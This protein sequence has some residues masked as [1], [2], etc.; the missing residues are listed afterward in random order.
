MAKNRKPAKPVE[1]SLLSYLRE[2][3]PVGFIV[4]GWTFMTI[5]FWPAV[6]LL[7]LGFFWLAYDIRQ[8]AFFIRLPVY[9]RAIL[10]A[11][12]VAA[13]MVVLW[14][15][16]FTPAPVEIRATSNT[17]IYGE[18]SKPNGIEWHPKTD[19]EF[20]LSIKNPTKT[21]YDRFDAEVYTDIAFHDLT[22]TDGLAKCSVAP[23]NPPIHQYVQRMRNGEPEGPVN[24]PNI[25][26]RYAIVPLDILGNIIRAPS[27]TDWAYR[28]RCDQ[29][30]SHSEADFYGTLVVINLPK[31]L[32]PGDE[33]PRKTPFGSPR[34][35]RL[36]SADISFDTAGRHRTRTISSCAMNQT[37]VQ[38]FSGSMLSFRGFPR[39]LWFHLQ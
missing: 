25:P 24:D 6:M 16:V 17:A 33:L 38:P 10:G 5:W 37:C 26:Q 30:P 34:A 4:I 35:A 8:Q 29:L 21:D 7:L 32:G 28:I 14:V 11:T 12:Y 2:G 15:W 36:V 27:G 20:T 1:K 22:Q 9:C 23:V 13:I 39:F 19:S 18:G 31:R 3:L